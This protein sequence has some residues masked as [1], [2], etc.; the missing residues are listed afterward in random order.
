MFTVDRVKRIPVKVPFREV[1]GRNLIKEQPNWQ[2]FEVVEVELDSGHAGYGEAMLD[3]WSR[4][5]E[6]EAVER[7]RGA[8]GADLMWEDSLGWALQSALFDAVGRAVGVPI[9][10]LLG[11]QVHERTPLAWWCIDMPAEDWVREA[12]RPLERGYTD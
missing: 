2:Y 3:Y 7:V 11:E 9:H 4:Q 1:P 6:E 8:N 12:E 10:R 5:L